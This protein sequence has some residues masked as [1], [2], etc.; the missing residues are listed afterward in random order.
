MAIWYILWTFGIFFP[1]WY[2]VPI[3]IWQPCFQVA[4]NY[5]FLDKD[6]GLSTNLHCIATLWIKTK[7]SIKSRNGSCATLGVL[8][9]VKLRM[10]AT[11]FFLFV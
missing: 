4:P 6:V 11:A 10:A 7:L 1:F 5:I 3:N 8:N 9:Q 2:V